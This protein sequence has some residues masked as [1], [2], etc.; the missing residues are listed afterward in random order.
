LQKK[1]LF[2]ICI[3]LIVISQSFFSKLAFAETT[4]STNERSDIILLG[5]ITDQTTV[6]R[7]TSV[8]NA[9]INVENKVG[10]LNST[11]ADSEGKFEVAIA[12][13]PGN[14]KLK[15]TAD[16]GTLPTYSIDVI[17]VATGWVQ[18]GNLWYYY[19]QDGEKQTGWIT[20]NNKRYFLDQN[21]AMKT[22]WLFDHGKWYFLQKNGV[23]LSGWLNDSG[24]WYFLDSA[25]VMKTGWIQ[26]A[27]RWYYLGSNGAMKTGWLFDHGKWYF[28]KN[29]GVMQLGW[30]YDRGKWYYLASNG[31]MATGWVYDGGK[32]YFLNTDGTMKTGWVQSGKDRFYLGS[33]G[34]VSAVML[35]APLVGQMP[36]LPRGC[37]VTSLAMMLLDSGK[38]VSK[39]TLATQVRKDPTPYS[40]TNG[41]VY[42]GN[43]YSGFVGD[44]YTF[45]KPGLGVYHGPIAELAEK[46]LPNRVVDFTGSNFEEI[47]KHL[48]NGKP[49][50]V[51]NN[52]MF[53]TVPSQ[54]WYSW[55]TPTGKISITYKEHSVLITGYDS[56]Y[57]YF[58]DPLS[59]TKNWKAPI[60]AFK[61]GWEQMGKQAITYR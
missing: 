52:V 55:N 1:F 58:N 39:M 42:F 31:A 53:D 19:G 12:K 25:G 2:T 47:Y 22:G 29:S 51:I 14:T 9:K 59:V 35:D 37:E 21:G 17:V 26:D 34:S 54:Y 5:K 6:I 44:M 27:K 49:V 38:N 18:K 23:M 46:Y 10:L 30:L 4:V 61:R 60:S 40:I 57:I 56:Q 36:E 32:W 41:Q 50:W 7:G 3:A 48:N 13:Q 11:Q 24:K 15:I 45:N 8:P 43:P 28:L 16:D 20:D 33:G